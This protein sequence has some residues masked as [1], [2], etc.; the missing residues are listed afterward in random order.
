MK[1]DMS[2]T[3]GTE[4]TRKGVF[5]FLALALLPALVYANSLLNS[6]HYDDNSYILGNEYVHSLARIPHFFV[7]PRL[8]SNVPLSGYRPLTMTTFALNYAAGANNPFGYHLVNVLIHV[9]NTLLVFALA[10]ATMRAFQVP[11]EKHA[12]V[13]VAAVFAIHPI[14]TQSVNYI[15][16]RSSLLVGGFSLLCILLYIKKY[17]GAESTKENRLLLGSLLAYGGALLSKEEAVAVPG[18]L[19]F[20]ELCRLRAPFDQRKLAQA[21]LSLAPFFL[22]TLAFLVYVT[23]GLGVI[24]DTPQAR[25][26]EENLLTQAKSIFI[27]VKM[28]LAPLNLSVDHT[29]PVSSSI[30]DPGALAAV[31]VLTAILAGSLSLVYLAPAVSLGVWWFILILVPTSTL[32]ALKLIVNE[33]RIYVAGVGLFLAGSAALASAVKKREREGAGQMKK[34]LAAALLLVLLLYSGITVYRNTQWRTPAALWSDALKKYPHS[35]RANTILANLHLEKNEPERALPLAEKAA[36]LGPDII[37]T[38]LVLARTYSRLGRQDEALQNARAAVDINPASSEA[39]TLLG[40][41]YARLEQ[42]K[43]AE[44]AWQTA[45][46]F[47]SQNA[48][49]RENLRELREMR[50]RD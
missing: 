38:R 48:E 13:A 45:V 40:V 23:Y 37:E 49:A 5:I 21:M 22:L 25:S 4:K 41:V 17:E 16:A 44:M 29:I 27:Y 31:L 12:A 14:N 33:Q 3:A 30:L 42:Y 10:T 7:S 32:V 36:G 47:D 6:F 8:I 11:Y 39:Q 15:S 1:L 19:A 26:L 20:F 50:T 18:V 2:R 24:G 46:E 35:V 28:I 9:A 34:L 43:E